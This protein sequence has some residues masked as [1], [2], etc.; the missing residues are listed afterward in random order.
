MYLSVDS[1]T[2]SYGSATL[3]T[4]WY[5]EQ[6][7]RD[8]DVLNLMKLSLLAPIFATQ[9]L[10]CNLVVSHPTFSGYSGGQF[11]DV[12]RNRATIQLLLSTLLQAP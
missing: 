12:F 10:E 7:V 11:S 2:S 6:V 5:L 9:L 8:H 3:S 1:I 4:F